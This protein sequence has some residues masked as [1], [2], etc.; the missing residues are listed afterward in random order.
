MSDYPL[1]IVVDENDEPIGGAK[2]EE[3]AQ[4]GLIHRIIRVMVE[5]GAGNVLLQKR[6]DNS[7]VYP[8]CWDTSAGGH[9]DVGESYLV[10]AKRELAEE[11]GL[12]GVKLQEVGRF[13]HKAE[14]NNRRFDR[15][16]GVYKTSVPKNTEFKLQE[17]EVSA[18][19]WFSLAEARQLAEQ[20][21]DQVTDGIPEILK[22]YY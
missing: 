20:H 4:K 16:V 11:I 9:V 10:A 13:R 3:I 21:P 15:F 1:A 7:W 6:V 8:G 17:S 19:K 14:F 18:V 5:D 2:V 22:R 12:S